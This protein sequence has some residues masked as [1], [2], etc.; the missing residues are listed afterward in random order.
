MNATSS[1][2]LRAGA[3]IL[4][5]LAAGCTTAPAAPSGAGSLPAPATAR[6]V[7]GNTAPGPASAPAG[8]V[9][10]DPAVDGDLSAKTEDSPAGTTFWLAPGTHTLGRNEFGQVSP[11]DGNTYLGAP[12]AVLDGREVNRY[13]FVFTSTNVT[14]KH[15]TIQGFVPPPDEGV[16]NHDSGDGWVIEA[17]TIQNNRGAGLMAGARQQVRGNCLRDNGQYA[18]NAYQAGDRITGL[19]I[20]NNE[21]SGNNADDIEATRPGCGCTGG[22]KFW[23]VNGADIRGNWVHHNRGVG[24]WADTNNNDFLFEDNVFEDND[25]AAIIYETSYNAVIRNNTMRRNNWVDGKAFAERGD[26]FPVATVYVSESGG[27]PRVKART[28]KIEFYGNTLQDN[29]SGVTLWENADRFCNSAANTSTGICT[30]LVDQTARCA[31]PEI[32]D[33]PLYADCRWRTQRVDIHHNLFAV[34]PSAIGCEVMCAR[35]AVLSNVGTFPDW[36]P[37]HGEVVQD[38]I[39]FK[40]AN[41]WHDNSYAGP[42]TFM[43]HDTGQSLKYYQWQAN[44]YGQDQGSAFR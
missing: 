13:A 11:K 27:E 21:I 35:M 23:A 36:S 31:A 7:C 33:P 24:L 38:S 34:D 43:P 17:N 28:D 19:V 39:T 12:G 16:V 26:N 29:W 37:Y 14:I 8:A 25:G 15:L 5:L 1:S 30:A 2:R 22:A 20:E 10:V 42:W 3:V 40:Q 6:A 32:A 9:P 18:I 4:G 44:P 41:S